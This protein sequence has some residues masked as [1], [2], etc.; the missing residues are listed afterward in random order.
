MVT[1]SEEKKRTIFNNFA[2][3]CKKFASRSMSVP[4]AGPY[5]LQGPDAANK[6]YVE[7]GNAY[8]VDYQDYH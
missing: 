5:P 3:D 8:I 4:V 2:I 6:D 7:D 1:E